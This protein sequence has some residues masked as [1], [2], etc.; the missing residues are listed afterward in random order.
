MIKRNKDL[1]YK[2]ILRN[3]VKYV[4]VS[5]TKDKFSI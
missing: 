1:Q 4:E 2:K 5:D 3:G